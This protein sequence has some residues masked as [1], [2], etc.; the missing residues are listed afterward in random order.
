[1]SL[2]QFLVLHPSPATPPHL[3]SPVTP[4]SSSSS[5]TSP[6]MAVRQ[7]PPKPQAQFVPVASRSNPQPRLAGTPLGSFVYS[8]AT[9]AGVQMSHPFVQMG[10]PNDTQSTDTQREQDEWMGTLQID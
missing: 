7:S 9:V 5:P 1:V 4:P 10:Q 8:D 6:L 2:T 3:H